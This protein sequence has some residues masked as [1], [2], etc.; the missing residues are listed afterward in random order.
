MDAFAALKQAM[1]QAPVLKLLDFTSDFVIETDASNVV[2][3]AVLTQQG[4]PIAYFSKKLG[5]KL[6]AF[7]TYIKE[8]HA[9]VDV[10]YKWREYLLGR[11][12]VIRTDHKSIKEL[13]Q[14]VIQTPD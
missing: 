12:F 1:V 6:R 5:P 3:G 13:L 11:F 4:H 8:L 9:I 2:I 7:S 14:Q 10:V